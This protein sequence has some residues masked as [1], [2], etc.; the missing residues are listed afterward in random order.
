MTEIKK[1]FLDLAPAFPNYTKSFSFSVHKA[2]SSLMAGLLRSYCESVKFPAVNIPETLFNQGF[3]EKD[4]HTLSEVSELIVDGY[5][6]FGFRALPEI[7]N[8]EYSSM[9]VDPRDYKTCLLVRD[10]RDCLV[11]QYFSMGRQQ[12][13][14][15]A[16]PKINPES[17]INSLK[18]QKNQE[19]DSYVL[20]H[21]PV[22][23][24][25]LTAYLSVLKDNPNILIFRY[26]DIYFDKYQ[27]LLDIL[28]W[29]GIPIKIDVVKKVAEK[30]DIRPQKEDVNSHIRK[31]QPGD[32]IEKLSPKTIAEVSDR[33]R[34]LMSNYG[35][36]L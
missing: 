20:T 34:D 3:L 10:P 22:L 2:G 28:E 12:A 9:G 21:S 27:F 17:F 5:L 8:P 25:K 7:L 35:Y 6:Y 36:E 18:S 29:T 13:S 16:L 24:N 30:H 1:L 23:F 11:S 4:W 26:E 14:S 33:F 31:G 15:H 32:H 19:I